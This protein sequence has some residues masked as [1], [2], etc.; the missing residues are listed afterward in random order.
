[1][2][3]LP[4]PGRLLVAN[5]VVAIVVCSLAMSAGLATMFGWFR[6]DAP[7]AGMVYLGFV[8]GALLCAPLAAVALCQLRGTFSG[9]G[10]A[11]R[12][13][14]EAAG[15]ASLFLWAATLSILVDVV[16]AIGDSEAQTGQIDGLIIP[17]A[18]TTGLAGFT[19]F[20]AWI[21]LRWS[22]ILI[23]I[24]YQPRPRQFSLHDLFAVT[25]WLAAVAG[26]TRWMVIAGR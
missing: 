17:L 1:M 12:T 24:G 23:A 4:K 14:A 20:S 2:N 25:I 19:T 10:R 3:E 9:D 26:V 15:L 8:F 13:V 21:N 6:P 7:L 11:A 16:V 22:R 5:S 18:W